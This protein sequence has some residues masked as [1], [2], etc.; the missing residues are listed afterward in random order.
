LGGGRA[1]QT[2][3]HHRGLQLLLGDLG[4]A[5]EEVLD[6]QAV[7]QLVHELHAEQ[8]AS[9]LRQLR[10]LLQRL[11]AALQARAE[12]RVAEV[13]RSTCG[14]AGELEGFLDH[15]FRGQR[16]IAHAFWFSSLASAENLTT[17][18]V[19]CT[20][21][22]APTQRKQLVP[23]SWPAVSSQFGWPGSWWATTMVTPPSAS[24]R[25]LCL[26]RLMRW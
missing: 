10:L 11:A 15:A 1:R 22:A 3:D 12:G 9:G 21:S 16:I 20:C 26:F 5:L 13:A 25:A 14:A 17:R 23:R 8:V 4:M 2:D 24:C 7:D 6:A 18:A 19:G